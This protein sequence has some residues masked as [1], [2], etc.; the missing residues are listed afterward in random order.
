MLAHILL[1]LISTME[2]HIEHSFKARFKVKKLEL[3]VW[4]FAI[5]EK[6]IKKKREAK[7]V[8]WDEI[9]KDEDLETGR[10]K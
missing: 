8:L 3:E 4:R 6:F 5:Y 7:I 2:K 9:N 1:F 10:N